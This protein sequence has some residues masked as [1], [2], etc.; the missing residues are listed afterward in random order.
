ME[1]YRNLYAS[2][3]VAGKV[4]RIK[5]KINHNAGM[6]SVYVIACPSN[7]N[8]LLDIIP[9]RELMQK[10]YPKRNMIIIGLAKGYQDALELVRRIID[11]TYQNTGTVD[12]RAYLK[13]GRGSL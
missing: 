8:N 11:E 5:W 2:D 12:V 4:N 9:A 1:W 13:E 10:S 7:P 3:S 6:V